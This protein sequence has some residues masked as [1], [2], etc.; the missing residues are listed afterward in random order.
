MEAHAYVA[1]V[2]KPYTYY[3]GCVD[4]GADILNCGLCQL[5]D[6]KMPDEQI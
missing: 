4:V 6:N 2:P 3:G 5:S 1:D